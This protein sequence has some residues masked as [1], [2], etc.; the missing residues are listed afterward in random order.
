MADV[1]NTIVVA[2]TKTVAQWFV[3]T[4]KLP[5]TVPAVV[6][7]VHHGEKLEKFNGLNFKR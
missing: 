3:P 5:P 1:I 4:V 7:P 6:I 2:T